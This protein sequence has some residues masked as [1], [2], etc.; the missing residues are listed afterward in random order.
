MMSYR[1]IVQGQVQGVF[2]RVFAKKVADQ[3]SIQG[4]VRNREDGSVE[5]LAQGPMEAFVRELR[6]GPPSATVKE[7]SVMKEDS[8]VG[9]GFSIH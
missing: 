8:P 6:K 1:I 3:L 4:W 2:F 9:K 7:V 5:I